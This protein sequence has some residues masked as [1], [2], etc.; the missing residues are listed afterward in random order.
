[1]AVASAEVK[2]FD[3]SSKKRLRKFPGHPVRLL[4]FYFFEAIFL[5][6]FLLL[7]FITNFHRTSV[8]RGFRLNPSLISKW[9]FVRIV[10]MSPVCFHVIEKL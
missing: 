4:Y 7:E 1:M 8:L 3:L 9:H 6:F 10:Y 5:H 2:L